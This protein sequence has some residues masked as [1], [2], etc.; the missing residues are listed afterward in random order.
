MGRELRP[1]IGYNGGPARALPEVPYL[2][3]DHPYKHRHRVLAGR[4]VAEHHRL[5]WH[6]RRFDSARGSDLPALR[7]TARRRQSAPTAAR[8]TAELSE[9]LPAPLQ[10]QS[11]HSRPASAAGGASRLD[12][13]GEAAAEEPLLV[14]QSRE[15]G[16]AERDQHS[17]RKS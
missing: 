5:L 3:Q 14:D 9:Q 16:E 6:E 2:P 4:Y 8:G 11:V 15:P 12:S 10:Q 17:D 7:H 13:Q 1:T